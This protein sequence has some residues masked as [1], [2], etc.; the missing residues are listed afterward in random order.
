VAARRLL[1]LS[2]TVVLAALVATLAWIA[3][4]CMVRPLDGVEGDVLFEAAR[5]RAH[6]PLYVDP[7]VGAHDYGAVPARFLVLYTPLWPAVLAALGA[8]ALAGRVVAAAAWLGV[9]AWIAHRAPPERRI[10]T[11][12]AALFA[13]STFVLALYGASARP[14]AAAVLVCGVALERAA[15][16]GDVDAI[17]G[18]LFA[19]A[20]WIKPNVVG[21]APGAF[22]VAIVVAR[23]ATMRGIAGAIGVSAALAAVLTLLFGRVWIDHLLAST[24]QPP[25][26]SH[27][28]EQMASRAPFFGLPLAAAI[29]VGWRARRDPGAA[30]ATGALVTSTLWAIVSLAK[31]GSASNYLMEP[32]VAAVVV[33]A[34]ADL[35]PLT[36]RA[37]LLG[38]VAIVAQTAYNGVASVRSALEHVPLDRERGRVVVEARTLCGARPSDVVIADEPGLEL[39]ADGRIV[40]TPFQSTHLARRGRFPVDKW[41]DD[42][43]RPEVGCLLMQDDLLERP[44]IDVDPEHD[45]FGPELRR[46]LGRHFVLATER[47]GIRVYRRRTV[48]EEER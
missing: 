14:D 23:R 4:T 3:A 30:I 34:R 45:R 43:T 36:A 21:V 41:I 10:A 18:A 25:S 19:L 20:A 26:L 8:S 39:M 15:R 40:E 13:A 29:A 35:P 38:A 32:M 12:A 44:C 5:I 48:L 9:F 24:G 17:A 33:V 22:V 2:A 46:A 11:R 42:V 28:S 27:W 47:A 31:I 7:T 37:S 6:L 1:L 16:K